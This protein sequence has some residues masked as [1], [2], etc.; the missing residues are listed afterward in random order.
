MMTSAPTVI[1]GGDTLRYGKG[2]ARHPPNPKTEALMDY[3]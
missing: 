1:S 2:S 3:T